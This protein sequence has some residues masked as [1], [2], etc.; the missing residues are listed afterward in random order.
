MF[1]DADVQIKYNFVKKKKLYFS[2]DRF[3]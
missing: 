2:V 1:L 3:Y